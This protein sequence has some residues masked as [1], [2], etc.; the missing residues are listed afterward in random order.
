MDLL[1]RDA[2][3]Y[4]TYFPGLKIVARSTPRD[5]LAPLTKG[6]LDAQPPPAHMGGAA[7]TRFQMNHHR[8]LLLSFTIV[9]PVLIGCEA[10][11]DTDSVPPS[12]EP[13]VYL[14]GASAGTGSSSGLDGGSE[15][16]AGEIPPSCQA[17][18]PGLTDCGSEGQSCCTNLLV[19]G[20]TYHRTYAYGDAGPTGRADLA[21]ISSFRLD[22]YDVTVGRFRQFVNAVMPNSDGGVPLGWTPPKDS[23]RHRYLNGGLGLVNSASELVDGGPIT[24]ES[25]WVT[26]HDNEIAPTNANLSCENTATWTDTP[27]SQENFPI[28][29]VN[30]YEAYAFCIWDKAFLPSEAEWEYAAAGGSEQREYPWGTTTPG[31]ACPGTGCEYA[32]YDCY[33]PNG[34]GECTGLANI[35]PVGTAT[36]GK[37][38]WGQLDLDGNVFQWTLDWY[39]TYVDPCTDC[40]YLTQPTGKHY[41]VMRGT[42]DGAAHDSL[43][44]ASRYL[45]EDYTRVGQTGFRCARTP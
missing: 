14:S 22:K 3:R 33:Y 13:G 20:G 41:R 36:R 23:G 27:G 6:T 44:P 15:A 30:W 19:D 29:C 42:D 10:T 2:S 25:G 17:T 18:G 16:D 40:A 31:T 24:Y 4:R 9:A 45:T 7:P 21:K 38:E 43:L 34:T 26:T 37:G 28:N 5:G 39:A 12:P 8:L 35:A 32:I 11:G 1:T